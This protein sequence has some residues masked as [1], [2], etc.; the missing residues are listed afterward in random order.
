[1][2]AWLTTGKDTSVV[3]HESALDLLDLSDVIPDS[4]HILVPRDR[5]GLPPWSGITLHTSTRP[6]L[7]ND[8]TTRNGLRLTAPMRTILDVAEAG[9]APEQVVQAVQQAVTKGLLMPTSL[10]QAARERG[11]RVDRLIAY[12]LEHLAAHSGEGRL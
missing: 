9:A 3:S 10:R 8:V 11:S 4:I 12:S 7:P 1:M 6:L 5:R 2:A